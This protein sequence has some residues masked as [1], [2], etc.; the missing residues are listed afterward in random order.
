MMGG[1]GLYGQPEQIRI[2][3]KGKPEKA[4]PLAGQWKSKLSITY[5]DLRVYR[6]SA[7]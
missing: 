2:Y 5:A 7:D 3:P 4:I 1:G 6:P